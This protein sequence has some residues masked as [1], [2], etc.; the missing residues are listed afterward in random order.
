[1]P[2]DQIIIVSNEQIPA[3]PDV[4]KIRDIYFSLDAMWHDLKGQDGTITGSSLVTYIQCLSELEEEIDYD[5]DIYLPNI[6]M[7]SDKQT[8]DRIDLY[9]QLG[10]VLGRLRSR[11]VQEVRSPYDSPAA[12]VTNLTYHNEVSSTQSVVINQ[13]F[14]QTLSNNID[15]L[16]AK[17]ADKS[18]EKNF[19]IS[20]KSQLSKIKSLAD[21][22]SLVS[23]TATSVGLAGVA[24]HNILLSLGLDKI[25]S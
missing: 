5:F 12:A 16:D 14:L 11:Y 7:V 25:A 4:Q 2:D 3:Q 20:L 10:G 8:C 21:L 23:T 1:M 22:I 6:E 17:L 19:V 9:T 18:P 15:S 24:L 13:E